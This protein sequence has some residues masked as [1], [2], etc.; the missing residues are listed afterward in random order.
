MKDSSLAAE[1]ELRGAAMRLRLCS[2]G[3]TLLNFLP[4]LSQ[5]TKDSYS[6][7]MTADGIP[8][9]ELPTAYDIIRMELGKEVADAS[10]YKPW[11]EGGGWH[12]DQPPHS[13]ERALKDEGDFRRPLPQDRNLCGWCATTRSWRR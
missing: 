8:I 7:R 3:F 10:G 6:G 12:G 2:F 13:V 5:Y 4:V 9:E 11:A 1:Q